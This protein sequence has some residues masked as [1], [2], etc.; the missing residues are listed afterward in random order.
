MINLNKL[1]TPGESVPTAFAKPPPHVGELKRIIR[2]LFS[3][4]VVVLG[5]IIILLTVIAAIFAPWLSPYDPNVMN[6]RD[7]LAQPSAEHLLGTDGLGRDTLSRMIYGARTALLVGLVAVGIGAI[8]GMTMG[9]LAGYFGGR[10]HS[11]IMRIVDALMAFPLVV[12]AMVLAVLLGGG[13]GNIMI[14]VGVGLAATYARVMCGLTLGVKQS[15]YVL[16]SRAGR[17]SNLRIMLRH[18][19]PNCFP[20]I[21][22][23]ITLQLGGAILIEASLSYLGLGIAAPE[24]AWGSMVADGYQYLISNP[25]LAL[26]PGVAIVIVVYSFNMVGDG[27]RD[28]LDP[29]LRGTL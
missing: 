13:I 20:P 11:I 28:A 26:V 7:S 19:L 18:I 14:A 1:R 24:A 3:R 10:T 17:A 12:K 6:M 8:I 27:L 4:W 22:V 16:A 23:L 2:I 15:D 5:L 25:V 21:I 9:L 29:R